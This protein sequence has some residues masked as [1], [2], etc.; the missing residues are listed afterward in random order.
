MVIIILSSCHYKENNETV[1][2][3]R[4]LYNTFKIKADSDKILFIN[5]KG[6][7]ACVVSAFN[8][9][10]RDEEILSSYKY[11]II[12][13]KFLNQINDE[14]LHYNPKIMIDTSDVLERLDLSSQ[15]LTIIKFKDSDIES[16][17]TL[18]PQIPDEKFALFFH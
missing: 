6:C 2:I 15:G 9:I 4:Y 3:N 11:I 1:V 14:E 18:T 17:L 10:L 13:K 5:S 12:T 7:P 8:Y 16:V